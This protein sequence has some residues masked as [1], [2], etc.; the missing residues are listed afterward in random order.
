MTRRHGLTFLEVD[1]HL[2]IGLVSD[3][4]LVSFMLPLDELSHIVDDLL[5]GLGLCDLLGFFSLSHHL[6][7]SDDALHLLLSCFVGF[8]PGPA[9]LLSFLASNRDHGRRFLS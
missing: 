9:D 6:A 5:F 8:S 4:Y 1:E 2:I 3:V 7:L